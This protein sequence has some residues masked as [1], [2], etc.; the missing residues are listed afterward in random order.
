[1]AKRCPLCA[2]SYEG[3]PRSC[4]NCGRQIPDYDPTRCE[5]CGTKVKPGQDTCPNCGAPVEDRPVEQA[6]GEPEDVFRVNLE[7][8]EST[9]TVSGGTVVTT[10]TTTIAPKST[11]C[12]I[13]AL[14]IVIVAAAVLPILLGI[15]IPA[16]AHYTAQR[17]LAQDTPEERGAVITPAPLPDSIYRATIVEGENTIETI[18]PRVMTD[19]PDSVAWVNDYSPAVAFGFTTTGA[20]SLIQLDASAPN[21]LVMSLLRLN[22]DGSMTFVRFNDDSDV[23]RDPSII[24]AVT[25]GDYIALLY[26]LGGYEYGEVRFVWQVLMPEIPT[27]LPD[28]MFTVS[29]SDGNRLAYYYV[30]IKPDSSYIF[31]AS[32]EDVDSYIELRTAG[33]SVLSDDDGG[34]NWSD[35]RLA[36]D[37]TALQAGEACLIV[38]PYYYSSS[39]TWGDV[40]VSFTE[41]EEALGGNK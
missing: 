12:G 16:I 23:G 8:G 13:K 37:A 40:R 31:E 9:V 26:D 18:W 24:E 20:H 38:R 32:S 4:P 6:T 39:N 3:N 28:T 5:F 19:L 10:T 30:E 1:V 25:A 34:D 33:G 21:D 41:G 15:A 29:L 2:Q 14:I 17:K 27:I 36:F 7:T 35:A 22:P 11:G